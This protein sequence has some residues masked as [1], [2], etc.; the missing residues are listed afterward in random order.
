MTITTAE[1]PQSILVA[2]DGSAE[3]IRAVKRAAELAKAV[4]A[5]LVIL[6]VVLPFIGGR[7]REELENLERIEH[8]ERTEYE[9]LQA[10]GRG[11]VATAEAAARKKTVPRIEALVEVGDDPAELIARVALARRARMIVLG[12]RG[13]GKIASIVLGCI[14]Y[15]ITHIS[16]MPV[17]IV[18]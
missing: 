18:P 5:T 11:I 3:A 15:K 8:S 12:R 13:R 16:K 4:D 17:M 6:H 14:S 1:P 2:V 9:L 7:A 10:G